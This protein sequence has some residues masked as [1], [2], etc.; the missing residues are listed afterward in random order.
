[1]FIEGLSYISWYLL[2]FAI[3]FTLIDT[4]FLL[5][6]KLK[7]FS[8]HKISVQQLFLSFLHFRTSVLC[9]MVYCELDL[10]LFSYASVCTGI[11]IY[12]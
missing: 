1:M 7:F 8:S 10:V 4:V 6:C 9:S 3:D 5:D 2:C 11:N 12:G